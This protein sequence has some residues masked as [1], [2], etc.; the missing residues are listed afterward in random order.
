MQSNI[1][2][3]SFWIYQFSRTFVFFTGFLRFKD[4]RV[5]CVFVFR[6]FWKPTWHFYKKVTKHK[7]YIFSK[8]FLLIFLGSFNCQRSS[9]YDQYTSPSGP[10]W[11]F[12]HSEN[13]WKRLFKIKTYW[14]FVSYKPKG[15]HPF[16]TLFMF[17]LTIIL[18]S[19]TNTNH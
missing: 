13:T 15:L 14:P 1:L 10:S 7:Y 4:I 19:E 11:F 2:F 9:S 5:T 18:T 6:F 16:H 12:G 17:S 3:P 8:K